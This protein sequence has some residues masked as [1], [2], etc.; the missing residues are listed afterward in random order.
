MLVFEDL[1]RINRVHVH[2]ELRLRAAL[3]EVIVGDAEVFGR[4]SIERGIIILVAR[5]EQFAVCAFRLCGQKSVV[6]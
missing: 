5:S 3:A 6:S 1:Q 4:D 2:A